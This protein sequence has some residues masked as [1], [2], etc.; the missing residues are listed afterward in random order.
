MKRVFLGVLA[1]GAFHLDGAEAA[2]TLIRKHDS[3]FNQ[4]ALMRDLIS[5]KFVNF[6]PGLS[7]GD[8][9][10]KLYKELTSLNATLGDVVRSITVQDLYYDDGSKWMGLSI[11]FENPKMKRIETLGSN[12]LCP[13]IF[14]RENPFSAY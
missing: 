12:E 4:Q 9:L 11:V 2:P 6:R 10:F 7:Q 8:C 13:T 5:S 1:I 14:T 3:V